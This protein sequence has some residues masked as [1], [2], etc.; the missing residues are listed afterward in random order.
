MS[1]ILFVH[2]TVPEYRLE[3]W[4]FLSQK[5]DVEIYA[6]SMDLADKIY[7]LEKNFGLLNIIYKKDISIEDVLSNGYDVVIL[8]SID[9]CKELYIS[10]VILRLKKQYGYKTIYWSEKWEAN[11][12]DQPFFKKI[13][14]LIHRMMI[15]LISSKCDLCVAAG[16]KSYEYLSMLG[17]K[18]EKIHIAIDSSTSPDSEKEINLR[19]VYGISDK[20]KVILFMGRLISRKGCQDLILAFQH[21]LKSQDCVLL[22]AGDGPEYLN[23]TKFANE[24][25]RIILTGLVQ[26]GS[27]QLFYKRADVFVLPSRCERG[28]IEAW[29]LTV[30]E[31]LECGVPV[32]VSDI[33]GAGYDIVDS[34]NGVVFSN[35][36]IEQLAKSIDYVI[37]NDYDKKAIM[38]SY[39][40]YSVEEMANSF[41]EAVNICIKC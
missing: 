38:Q 22:I 11:W 34:Y 29:G 8:P 19:D 26:P 9:T 1:K 6:L 10:N 13:K 35:G 12:A 5:N 25:S 32:V 40:R 36:N 23:C 2:N 16:T 28:I 15:Y 21:Y 7:N 39:K 31:A 33:V 18:K 24:D 20:K 27:R 14:N 37:N 30:N 4:K 3:F 17:I 41:N